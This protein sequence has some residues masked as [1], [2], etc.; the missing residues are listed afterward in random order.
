MVDLKK[1]KEL[2][3]QTLERLSDLSK[4]LEVKGVTAEIPVWSD[5][6]TVSGFPYGINIELNIEDITTASICLNCSQKCD[7][8]ESISIVQLDTK[9][10]KQ[11]CHYGTRM[12]EAIKMIANAVKAKRIS[13]TLLVK[14]GEYV[15]K[16]FYK[17]C[18][19]N[20]DDNFFWI[21]V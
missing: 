16:G 3:I 8:I 18:G 6:G 14:D 1:Q 2:F 21:E 4:D 5:E 13:G 10:D 17:K 12:I 15:S 20:T 11:D 7:C 9:E 19:F